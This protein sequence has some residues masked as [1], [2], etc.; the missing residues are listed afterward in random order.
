MRD[1]DEEG[2]AEPLLCT[3]A[4]REVEHEV[5][6]VEVAPH[7]AIEDQ[8]IR[9]DDALNGLASDARQSHALSDER[10]RICREL[11][12]QHSQ[13]RP[14]MIA[15]SAPD[16]SSKRVVTLGPLVESAQREK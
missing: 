4:R 6:I 10:G 16:A 11:V 12:Q 2:S 9:G 5:F 15:K 7:N 14:V 3:D 13:V 8:L 1:G